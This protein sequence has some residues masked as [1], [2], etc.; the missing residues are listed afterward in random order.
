MVLLTNFMLVPNIMYEL[1]KG[2]AGGW[3]L[4]S[5][6]DFVMWISEYY[7]DDLADLLRLGR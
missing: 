5:V 2:Q 7:V 4:T 6:S 3:C 1:S